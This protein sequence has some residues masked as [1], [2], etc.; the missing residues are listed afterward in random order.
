LYNII[1]S[2]F[3]DKDDAQ[4]LSQWYQLDTNCIP[5]ANERTLCF[6]REIDDVYEHLSNN[7]AG[8]Y[9]ELQYLNDGT[10]IVNDEVEKL[11]NRLKYTRITNVLQ[12]KNMYR[13]KIR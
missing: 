2:D 10:P 9:I 8:K 1:C 13:Y 7:K 5:N 12:S 3:D 11:L 4:L 6:F